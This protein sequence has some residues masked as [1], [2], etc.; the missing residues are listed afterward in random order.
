[1]AYQPVERNFEN[2]ITYINE[3]KNTPDKIGLDALKGFLKF[4]WKKLTNFKAYIKANLFPINLNYI[5]NFYTEDLIKFFESLGNF[6]T[7]N[8]SREKLK[9]VNKI[10]ETLGESMNVIENL[11]KIRE[12]R[13]RHSEFASQ[14]DVTEFNEGL[15][16]F[17]KSLK[18]EFPTKS[19]QTT[20]SEFPYY[21]PFL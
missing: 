19:T 5:N 8:K 11:N 2:V 4:F 14:Q 21:T 6:Y 13:K 12:F 15:K 20:R 3:Y 16:N 10:L 9:I 7:V 18:P 17:K 1:M